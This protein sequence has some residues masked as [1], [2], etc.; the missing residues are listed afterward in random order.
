MLIL[1]LMV[2]IH[3]FQILRLYIE[4][5]RNTQTDEEKADEKEKKIEQF[6]NETIITRL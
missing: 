6:F 4:E 1:V 5:K 2:I 3:L